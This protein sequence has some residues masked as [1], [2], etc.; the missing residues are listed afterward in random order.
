MDSTSWCCC[1]LYPPNRYFKYFRFHLQLIIIKNYLNVSLEHLITNLGSAML[2]PVVVVAPI[3]TV[4]VWFSTVIITTVT[5]HCG[6]HFP[7]LKSPQFHNYHHTAFTE[8]F[9]TNGVMDFI[10]GTDKRFRQSINFKRH[11]VFFS[12]N[13]TIR[14]IFVKK[15]HISKIVEPKME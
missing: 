13:K 11:R 6:Y 7:F 12:L 15:D 2:G 8:C 3:S 14:D 5:D 9:G 10:C 1:S 4:W